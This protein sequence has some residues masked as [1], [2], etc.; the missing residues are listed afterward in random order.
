MNGQKQFKTKKKNKKKPK[1]KKY[2]NREMRT[3]GR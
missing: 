3:Y 1:N 2:L